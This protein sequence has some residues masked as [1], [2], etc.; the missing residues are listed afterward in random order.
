M[1]IDTFIVHVNIVN[2]KIGLFYFAL[3]FIEIVTES[4]KLTHILNRERRIS[5]QNATRAMSNDELLD[6]VDDF[7]IHVIDCH[8]RNTRTVE[9]CFKIKSEIL[10]T[11]MFVDRAE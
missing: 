1:I 10:F 5:F 8:H 9:C 3:F 4:T 11:G 7:L 2:A 6:I